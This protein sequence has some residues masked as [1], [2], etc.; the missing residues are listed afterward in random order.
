VIWASTLVAMLVVATQ[1]SSPSRSAVPLQ[2]YDTLRSGDGRVSVVYRPEA[3]SRAETLLRYF[4]ESLPLPGLPV[5]VPM[6]AEIV[7]APSEALFERA[8]GARV[9][10]WGAAVAI[11]AESRIVLPGYGS[12]RGRWNEPRTLRHEWAHLGLHGYLDGLR[13][14]RWFSEGYA[15]W[16]SGG[17][18]WEGGWK[19]RLLLARDGSRLDSLDLRWP[20][21]R[22]QAE[23]AYLLSASA[24]EY[25]ATASSDRALEIFLT[26][27]RE[28]EDFEA[29][30]RVTFGQTSGNF[31]SD[32][33]KFVK[34]RYGWLFVLSHSAVFWAVLTLASVLMWR[35]RRAGRRLQMARLRASEIPERPAYWLP[36]D[37]AGGMSLAAK[38]KVTR[39]PG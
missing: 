6:R 1:G 38:G 19:L 37:G 24:V 30:F 26:R 18:N 25:L 13:I 32:W 23:A 3:R 27:W 22:T 12:N 2:S 20:R 9:P 21:S 15:E 8:V 33:K 36:L 28:M 31:E 14:P 16:A 35:T 11:P 17:W 34:R 4:D 10:E 39:P 5:G 29:A 7:L